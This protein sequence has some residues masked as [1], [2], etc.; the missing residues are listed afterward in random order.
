MI[1]YA[2]R[3]IQFCPDIYR[4]LFEFYVESIDMDTDVEAALIF[5]KLRE[6]EA[7]LFV[8]EQEPDGYFTEEKIEFKKAIE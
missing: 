2:S 7:F 3:L 6:L 4:S 8:E 1:H 5:D